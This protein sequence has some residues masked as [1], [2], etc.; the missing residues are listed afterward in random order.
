MHVWRDQGWFVNMFEVASNNMEDM[1][2]EFT[3]LVGEGGQNI[4]KGGWQGGR[5]WQV[6]KSAINSTKAD[7]HDY[8]LAGKWM[9]ENVKEAL[10]TPNE[11]FFDAAEKKLYLWPNSTSMAQDGSPAPDLKLVAVQLQTLIAING[12]KAAPTTNVTVQGIHFRDGANINMEP[13]GV[14]SGG[15]WGLY[16]GGAIF[17][18][19]AEDVDVKHND[20]ERLDGNA[21]FVSGYTRRM[22]IEDNAFSWLGDNAMAS[23]GYTKENDGMD[24]QQVTRSRLTACAK[25]LHMF[26]FSRMQTPCPV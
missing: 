7:A 1:S 26:L 12:T 20:F 10:D 13:W 23:W 15:D 16:R 2:M 21:V 17:L 4:V 5:G 14:P 25:V 3:T 9:I 8:L 11:W 22:H 24:G 6:N 18:E 19:G